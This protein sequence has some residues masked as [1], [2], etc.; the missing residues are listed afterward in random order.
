MKKLSLFMLLTIAIIWFLIYEIVIY[1]P[2]HAVILCLPLA[3]VYSVIGQDL[4]RRARRLLQLE[5]PP[6]DSDDDAQQ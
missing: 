4:I 5:Q 1:F 2:D 6:S 3:I